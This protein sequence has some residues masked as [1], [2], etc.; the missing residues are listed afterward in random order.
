MTAFGESFWSRFWFEAREVEGERG[1]WR[2]EP[3]WNKAGLKVRDEDLSKLRPASRLNCRFSLDI[4]EFDPMLD[5]K[6]C[7][8]GMISS[9]TMM[10][11]GDL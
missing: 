9:M 7:Y 3:E 11:H 6:Y 8:I 1:H 10:V 2:L 5:F 4:M